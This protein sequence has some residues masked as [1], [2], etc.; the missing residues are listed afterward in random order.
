VVG[1]GNSVLLPDGIYKVLLVKKEGGVLKVKAHSILFIVG[2]VPQVD[3][4][5]V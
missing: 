3:L 2:Q 4:E 1:I 5:P